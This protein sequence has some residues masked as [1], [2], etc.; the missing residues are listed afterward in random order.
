MTLEEAAI[1]IQNEDCEVAKAELYRVMC[2]YRKMVWRRWRWDAD[3]A[4]HH[5][6]VEVLEA[7]RAHRIA[8]LGKIQSFIYIIL[9]RTNWQQTYSKKATLQLNESD[10]ENHVV[11]PDVNIE[12]I[13]LLN[14]L[15]SRLSPKA[16]EVVIRF[17]LKGQGPEQIMQELDLTETQYR[18]M[19]NRSLQKMRDSAPKLLSATRLTNQIKKRQ[20]STSATA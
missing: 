4:I 13:Q 17:Y 11:E 2:N 1:R 14:T 20:F 6:Y 10:M 9:Q 3:D 12:S 15:T 8:D 7:I 18:L 5:A 19:K 16:R